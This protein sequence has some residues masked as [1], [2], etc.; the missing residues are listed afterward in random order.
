[1]CLKYDRVSG[2]YYDVDSQPG[3]QVCPIHPLWPTTEAITPPPD[4]DVESADDTSSFD[5][6]TPIGG[7]ELREHNDQGGMA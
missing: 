7:E 3:M 6:F 1:M 4:A 2:R 5:S